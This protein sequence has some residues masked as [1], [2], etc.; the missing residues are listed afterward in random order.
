MSWFG[1][2][3]SFVKSYLLKK[4]VA[5]F[6]QNLNKPQYLAMSVGVGMLCTLLPILIFQQYLCILL[7][8]IFKRW[9]FM[10]FSLIIALA[11]TIASNVATMPFV[12][13]FYYLVGVMITGAKVIELDKFIDHLKNI[14]D[15]NNQTLTHAIENSFSFVVDEVGTPL[16]IGGSICVAFFT[17]LSYILTYFIAKYISNRKKASLPL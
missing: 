9:K 10:N 2:K 15:I 8:F 7:W 12:L 6:K 5:P 13:Y 4:F 11:L 3:Y 1:R 16:L 14:F 17:I